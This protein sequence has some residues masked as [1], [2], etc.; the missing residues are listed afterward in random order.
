MSD[1]FFRMAEDAYLDPPDNTP[2]AGLMLDRME[3]I[4]QELLRLVEEKAALREWLTETGF[5]F[6]S[7]RAERKGDPSWTAI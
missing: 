5:G 7:S 1:M 6:C 4:D 2:D 3:E